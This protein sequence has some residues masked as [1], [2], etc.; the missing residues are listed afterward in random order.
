[1][2]LY[3]ISRIEIQALIKDLPNKGSSGYDNISNLLLKSLSDQISNPLEKIFNKS[4]E[5][6]LFPTNMKKADIVSLYKSKNARTKGPSP[7]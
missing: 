3:P 7:S 5:E 2:F 1:M 6:G 4:L